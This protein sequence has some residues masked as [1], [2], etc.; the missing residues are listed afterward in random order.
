MVI[1]THICV[2]VYIYIYTY[3][4]AGRPVPPQEAPLLSVQP[5]TE[6]GNRQTDRQPVQ[7]A[8]DAHASCDDIVCKAMH[9]IIRV[10]PRVWV[11]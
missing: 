5:D 9:M 11:Q 10:W 8:R 6:C 1:Y 2:C 4:M 7:S 3:M